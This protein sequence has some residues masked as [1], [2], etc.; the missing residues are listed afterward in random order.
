GAGRGMSFHPNEVVRRG[1]AANLIACGA[2]LFL[3]SAFFRT[4]IVRNEQLFLQS[5][6]NRL[7]QV[8]LPAPRGII[9]DRN[10]NVIADNAVGYSVAVLVQNNED[11]LRATMG[12][13]GGFVQITSRQADQAIQRY[14]RDRGRPAIILPD[15]SFDVV[16]V[17]EEHRDDVKRG[18]WKND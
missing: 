3:L 17:L 1:H 18:V 15:A 13:L 6:E 7:R 9:Y 10:N 12:R 2:L 5:E 4:Q 8:P 14:R 11:S 16:S